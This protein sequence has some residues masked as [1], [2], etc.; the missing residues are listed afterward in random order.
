MGLA[1]I[2]KVI[3][4]KREELLPEFG[5][6]KYCSSIL[7]ACETN[8]FLVLSVLLNLRV[9]QTRLLA[10]CLESQQHHPVNHHNLYNTGVIFSPPKA[11]E[12]ID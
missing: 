12:A 1:D 7:C 5:F 8:Q 6:K 11:A 2:E 9:Y 4:V 3:G 10:R